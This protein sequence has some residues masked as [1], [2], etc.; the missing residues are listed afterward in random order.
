MLAIALGKGLGGGRNERRRL[1]DRR[2]GTE[3]RNRLEDELG[4]QR[5]TGVDRRHA[6]RRRLTGDT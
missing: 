2:S 6:A 1:A 5:R 4:E 3:R